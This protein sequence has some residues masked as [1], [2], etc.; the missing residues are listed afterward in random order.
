MPNTTPNGY[1]CNHP[2]SRHNLRTSWSHC[3]RIEGRTT[4]STDKTHFNATP[5]IRSRTAKY[6]CS[7][8]RNEMSKRHMAGDNVPMPWNNFRAL[9][10]LRNPFLMS[11]SAKPPVK[12]TTMKLAACGK[13]D[14]RPFCRMLNI[15]TS[16][17]YSGT[18]A[19]IAI[20]NKWSAMHEES[21]VLHS[22]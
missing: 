2:R 5:M 21:T 17:I 11:K 8:S 20:E 3:K 1:H 15:R 7:Q 18:T 14:R 10:R 12:I 4:E 19:Q 9:T 13:A 16:F 22:P 6:R